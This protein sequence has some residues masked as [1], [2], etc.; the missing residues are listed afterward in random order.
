MTVKFTK[1]HFLLSEEMASHALFIHINSLCVPAPLTS[2]IRAI[3]MV[4]KL[5]FDFIARTSSLPVFDS[6]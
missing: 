4:I 5:K 2:K 1:C 3:S 6:I